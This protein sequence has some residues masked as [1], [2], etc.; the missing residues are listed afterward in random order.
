MAVLQSAGIRRVV[1]RVVG[2]MVQLSP[3]FLR[4]KVG[5]AVAGVE[6][7]YGRVD[8]VRQRV[9]GQLG[10]VGTKLER[11]SKCRFRS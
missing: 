11:C 3:V 4:F 8:Q 9:A 1:A 6:F 5:V 2:Q 7:G 10:E